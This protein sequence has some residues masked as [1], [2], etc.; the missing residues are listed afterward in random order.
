GDGVTAST[1]VI[2]DGGWCRKYTKSDFSAGIL[3]ISEGTSG[4]TFGVYGRSNSA[5]NGAV[6][7]YGEALGTAGITSGVYGFEASPANNSAGVRGIDY[8]GSPSAS[9]IVSSAGVRG[10]SKTHIG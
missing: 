1:T 10:E 9:Y 6:G 3:R 8:S 4:L 5:S 7:T 2:T